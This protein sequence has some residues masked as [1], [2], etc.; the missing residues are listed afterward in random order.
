MS[1]RL[2]SWF[3][4]FRAAE[5]SHPVA[6]RTDGDLVRL[7]AHTRD[8]AAFAE[9]L[10]RHGPMVLATCRRVLDRDTHT[11]DDAFQAA[12][13]VLATRAAAIR[14][15]ERVGAWLHGVAVRVAKKARDW[16]RKLASL[17]P[18]DLDKVPAT[19]TDP[20][21]DLA[22]I[23]ALI[24]EVLAN[25]PA[26]YR[27]PVVLCELE[28]VSRAQAAATL[29][30]SEGTLSGRLARAKKLL[31]ARLARRGVTLPAAG[32]AAVIL[33]RPAAAI[34]PPELAASTLQAASLVAA[35]AAT[36]E[37]TSASVATLTRGG[38][39]KM[40]TT[41]KLLA[42]GLAGVALALSGWGLAALL[43]PPA[44]PPPATDPVPAASAPAVFVETPPVLPR[45]VNTR[46]IAARGA[47]TAVSCG[48]DLVAVGDQDGILVLFDAKTGR[49]KET[50]LDGVVK[51]GPKPIDRLQFGPDGSWLYIVTDMGQSVH[52]CQVEQENRRFASVGGKGNWVGFGA[53]ADG[54]YWLQLPAGSGDLLLGETDPPGE[55]GG[56]P[57]ALFRH[58]A[59]VEFVAA[60]TAEAVAS[61]TSARGNPVLRLWGKGHEK[62]LW[63]V[64][65]WKEI[66]NIDVTGVAIA[67][68]GKLVAVV[69]D[70]GAVWVF[71][72]KT[73]KRLA[74]ADKLTGPVNDVAF[75]RDGKRIAVA[76]SDKTARV[77]DAATGKELVVLKGHTEDVTC[78]AFSPD[79]DTITTGSTDKTVKVWV[80]KK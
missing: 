15:P 27:A 32:L 52:H 22:H 72:G 63:E 79:G 2:R 21:P 30:C 56:P 78:V 44:V 7:F 17:A 29:G 36:D 49:E 16:V 23:R 4:T 69:G 45:W 5:S 67:A 12:F 42:G 11:A 76:C 1:A 14:P 47:V 9:L 74:A 3:Q 65:L 59:V 64:D 31:A 38:Y 66:A 13:L 43:G 57:A 6:E 58:G 77:I 62:P 55:R 24:D 41:F 25:L 37:V 60:D 26:K 48:S 54:K 50:L 70:A 34:V 19:M 75:S 33:A 71:D 8:E 46:T 28:G 68:G 61:V 39:P 10:H 40:T 51:R 35:G 53:T 80:L 20:D 73:G 18:S